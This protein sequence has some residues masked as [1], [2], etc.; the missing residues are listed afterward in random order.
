MRL[1]RLGGSWLGLAVL[2]LV[3]LQTATPFAASSQTGAQSDVAVKA[4][5]I[6][7]FA[8]FTEWPSLPDGG[9]LMICVA[10][11]DAVAAALSE[12][13]QGQTV[14]GH[15]FDVERSL[16]S[17]TWKVCHLLYVADTETRR[18]TA[19][20]TGLKTL[21]VL[22]VSDSKGFAQ[23]G[24]IVE[25]YLETG[26]MRFAINVTAAER[27]GLRLNSRLLGLA[28]IVRTEDAR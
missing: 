24:G 5:F 9:F 15:A 23:N 3:Q 8:K 13:V 4:A 25:L 19:G 26:R 2:A 17:A 7:N 11:D 21:P 22:T 1:H 18:S 20:L 6:Y 10:G 28:R 12:T 14:G 27:S 16:N